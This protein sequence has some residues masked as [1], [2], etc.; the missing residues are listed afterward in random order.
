MNAGVDPIAMTDSRRAFEDLEQRAD[1]VRRHIGPDASEEAAM[2]AAIG[3]ESISALID[4]V[5]PPAIRSAEPLGIGLART[6]SETLQHLQRLA[7]RNQPFRSLIG[8]GY[9]DCHT[10]AVIQRNIL[11]NPAW[12]T[13]YTPYQP[14]ISQGRLEALLNFQTMI[15]DLTGLEIA[16][17]SMLDE[18]TAAAEAMAF[19]QRVSK[20]RSRTFLVATGLPSADHRSR[21][22]AGRANRHRN[23][24]RRSPLAHGAGR[25]FRRAAAISLHPRTKCWTTPAPQRERMRSALSSWSLRIFLR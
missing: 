22:H 6:E 17:A 7:S 20:S 14:E 5:I 12:Y 10:P 2:L 11:E 1:F 3:L 18:G 19:C 21:A 15:A 4:E 23:R 25:M 16:N 13:A 8:M 24:G 9:Y